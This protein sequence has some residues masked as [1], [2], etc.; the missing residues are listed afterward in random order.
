MLAEELHFGRAGRHLR[1]SQT[2]VSEQLRQLESSI[3][4]QLLER[5]RRSVALTRAGERFLDRARAI[6]F[7]VDDAARNARQ[8]ADGIAGQLRLG[9][10]SAAGVDLV[11]RLL[12]RL[13][14]RAPDVLVT[15]H[16]AGTS[17]QLAA[18]RGGDLDAALVLAP[19]DH[20][21][22]AGRCVMAEPLVAVLPVSHPLAACAEVEFARFVQER[23]I[24]LA[25]RGE[26]R[27][28]E[29]FQQLCA[30]IG[31]TPRI[32]HEVEHVDIMLGLVAH[33]LGVSLG[34]R[35]LELLAREGVALR[36][37]VGTT[38]TCGVDLLWR[39]R[40]EDAVLNQLL[41]AAAELAP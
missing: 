11:P 6:L 2:A 9:F 12:A 28:F 36:P 33:G 29:Y 15:L 8:V 17:A 16:E 40:D 24:W 39:V 14:E 23:L 20:G 10:V 30:E 22:L 37:L 18:L 38:P 7:D 4:A 5:S 34:P 32:V 27:L 21:E 41:A 31:Q 25:R 35:T 26:P 3:G 13:R 1:L 19:I